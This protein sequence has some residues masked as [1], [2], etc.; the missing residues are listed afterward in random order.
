M[1]RYEA[2]SGKRNGSRKLWMG[3]SHVAPGMF[4]GDHHH[5]KAETG[6]YVVPA[7]PRS[8]SSRTVDERLIE[9]GP[10]RL[11][12]RAAMGAAPR[13][14]PVARR[15]DDRRAR[16]D[17]A[18][19]DRGQ[20]AQPARRGTRART[21]SWPSCPPRTKRSFLRR[22]HRRPSDECRRNHEGHIQ[23]DSPSRGYI[24]AGDGA[25]DQHGAPANSAT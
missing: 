13:G 20:P 4:S 5:G 3:K 12:L 10:G 25:K 18:G 19:G 2:I 22:T 24:E 16:P 7:Y 21:R 17:D 8:C 15:G 23:Q 6:I 11:H 9:T 1:R 14:E